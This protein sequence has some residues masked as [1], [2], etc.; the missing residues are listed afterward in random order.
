MPSP[1]AWTMPY[2]ETE[3]GHFYI[4]T[5]K[6][7]QKFKTYSNGGARKG[8]NGYEL[9]GFLSRLNYYAI[10]NNSSAEG[11]G[12]GQLFLLD[13]KNGF[14][15]PVASFG[16]WHVGLPLPS[17]NY[18]NF[19]YYENTA[20][21]HKN[22]DIGVLQYDPKAPVGQ[23]WKAIASLHS[24]DF[25]VE[26]IRWASDSVFYIKGYEEVYQQQKWLK[27]YSYYQ[28]ELP[29]NSGHPSINRQ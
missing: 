28:V 16:D 6:G 5:A 21:Q 15:Y 20:Y 7:R 25:A 27:N 23:A 1:K 19:V 18:L 22:T 10:S 8:W 24:N 29:Q 26:E 13:A 11:I 12:F 4:Q 17:V 14:R 2:V 9:L 3:N